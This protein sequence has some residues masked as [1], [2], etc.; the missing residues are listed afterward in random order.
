MRWFFFGALTLFLVLYLVAQGTVNRDR[1]PNK[2]YLRWMTDDNPSRKMQIAGFTKLHPNYDLRVDWG[3]GADS[4]KLLVQCA[5]G[6][7]PDIID[8]YNMDQMLVMKE[9]G[10]LLDLTPYAEKMGFG[11]ESTYPAIRPRLMSDGKQYRYPCNVAANCVVFNKAVFDDHG[12][13]YPTS[14]WTWED[15][16]ETGR[17]LLEN[18]SKSGK[19]HIVLAQSYSEGLCLDLLIGHGGRLFTENGLCSR[20]NAPEAIASV[21]LFDD[22]M[23]KYHILPTPTE[24]ASLAA[25]GGWGTGDINIFSSGR[26]AMMMIGRWYIIQVPNFPEIAQT[27]GAV[28]FPH[29]PGRISRVSCAARAAGINVFSPHREEALKFLQY[30]A[31]PEYGKIIVDGGDS[32]PP[33]PALA[34]DGETLANEIV[35]DPAFHQPFVD[36]INTA[37]ALDVSDFIDMGL[38]KRWFSERIQK[39]ANQIQ[40]PRDACEDMAREINLQIRQNLERR[41]DLRERFERVTGEPYTPDWWKKYQSGTSSPSPN[42]GPM[43]E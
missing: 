11:P 42:K 13:P 20:L 40:S 41:E 5:S 2:V 3:L 1:D 29:F 14:D 4:S 26:A 33:N 15:F 6:V 23:H 38:M 19:K 17:Q 43:S 10:I 36:A 18:P 39:V 34:Q 31:S 32:L 24:T 30:L 25:Q 28:Q 21:Q 37:R 22:L 16:I 7:G 9:A 35:P 8:L 12:V 27:L